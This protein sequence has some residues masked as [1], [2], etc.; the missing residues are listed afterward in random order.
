MIPKLSINNV[1]KTYPK[2]QMQI[3]NDISLHVNPGEFVSILGPSGC[4]KST[5]FHI[6][7]GIEK[8]SSGRITIDSR[9]TTD[10]SSMTGYMMQNP[11]LLPWRTVVDNLLLGT[12]I[13]GIPK[14]ES[15]KQAEKLLQQFG[16]EEYK[17][18]FPAILSGGMKQ[19]VALL[20]TLLFKQDL[21]LLDE[22]FGAL[23]AL[24]R[25]SCQFWL[26]DVWKKLRSS[27]LFITHD[28]AEAILLS[29]RIYVMSPRPAQIIAECTVDLPRPRK[30]EDITNKKAVKLEKELMKILMQ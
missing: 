6:V 19:R 16:L 1:F 26:L 18:F 4:G 12:D 28:I 23:D 2:T 14:K 25:L 21:L 15:K 3:L 22:P 29:D 7:A 17:D 8:P 11:L 24:T 30:K 20:R 27:I 13:R 5:L 10:R 9:E